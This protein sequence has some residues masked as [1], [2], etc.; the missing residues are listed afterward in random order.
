[1]LRL[2]NIGLSYGREIVKDISLTV[3]S[4]EIIGIV[5]RSGAGKTS[6]LKILSGLIQ[7][8][9]GKVF[10]DG[11]EV[12]GPMIKLVPGHPEIQ[13]VN[14]DFHLDTYHTVEENIREQIL[15]LPEVFRKKMIT[16]LLDL[17]G[18]EEYRDQ[19]AN[20]L[21]GG[22]QQRLA[23]ARALACEPRF[24][25]LD[26]PF[27]H[28]DARIRSKI[29]RYLLALRAVRGT[30]IV[31][32]S[33]DGSE[34]LS[35]TDKVYCMKNGKIYRSGKP[36]DLYYRPKTLEEAQLFGPVNS[37]KLSGKRIVFRPDEYTTEV[38]HS[39]DRVEVQFERSIFNGQVNENY[40]YTS[41]GESIMLYSMKPLEHVSS[42]VIH[43]KK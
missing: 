15:Y 28:L 9:S 39:V 19:R 17:V 41:N 12:K 20:T 38:E 11:A 5:G 42:F 14:Q 6:I 34:M 27:V 21:S 33:H 43:R 32:V 36:I 10:L 26:E 18:L 1:M 7:P 8:T 13:L 24:L 29:V 16:E 3:N 22:E 40:F 2:E 30:T 25:L 35:L 37:I 23:I 4:S 31:L